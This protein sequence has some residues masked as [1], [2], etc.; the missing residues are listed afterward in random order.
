MEAARANAVVIRKFHGS[1]VVRELSLNTLQ[2]R[3]TIRGCRRPGEKRPA[4]S[5]QVPIVALPSVIFATGVNLKPRQRGLAQFG[6]QWSNR[7][8][9]PAES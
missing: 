7:N 3:W 4:P 9:P 2:P 1:T 8:V 5:S 6:T